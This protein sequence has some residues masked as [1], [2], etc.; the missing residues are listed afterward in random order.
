[1]CSP[2]RLPGTHPAYGCQK[3]TPL[4]IDTPLHL[5][6]GHGQT[7]NLKKLI[8]SG[9]DP[10]VRTTDGRT[11]YDVVLAIRARGVGP[12]RHAR[13]VMVA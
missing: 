2:Y 6:A 8:A 7:G 5:A 9:G 11:P 4:A 3:G 13:N 10:E 12:D 1:M